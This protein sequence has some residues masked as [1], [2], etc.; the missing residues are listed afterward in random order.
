[1]IDPDP[2][3]SFHS[4]NG[5]WR[6][7]WPLEIFSPPGGRDNGPFIQAALEVLLLRARSE[8]FSGASYGE[9]Q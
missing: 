8:S 4:S 2:F 5:T 7:T 3:L 9:L 1:M 6:H